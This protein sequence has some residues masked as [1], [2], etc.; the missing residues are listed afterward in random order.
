MG[1]RGLDDVLASP[2]TVW[3]RRVPGGT[4]ADA[5][6]VDASGVFVGQG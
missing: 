6:V 3:G 5:V 2:W 4:D 1:R